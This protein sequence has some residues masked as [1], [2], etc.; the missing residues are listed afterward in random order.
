[1]ASFSGTEAEVREFV[2]L[3]DKLLGR[4]RRGVHV[5]R[6]RHVDMPDTWDGEG[7]KPPGW[8]GDDGP[9]LDR[10]SWNTP[11][12][13]SLAESELLKT[14]GRMTAQEKVQLSTYL[15]RVPVE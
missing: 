15:L 2:D 13:R 8:W 9:I 5:G 10:G 1:M 4:P 6:G 3:R 14:N 7:R 12:N 11:V